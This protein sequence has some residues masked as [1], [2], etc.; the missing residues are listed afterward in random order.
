[1][2]FNKRDVRG[3]IVRRR[4][5]KV[6]CASALLAAVFALA[7]LFGML[8]TDNTRHGLT[9]GAIAA[10]LTP[11]VVF[12]VSFV[13]DVEAV[14][15]HTPHDRYSEYAEYALRLE[16]LY[17]PPL[18]L[19]FFVTTTSLLALRFDL[20]S[21]SLIGVTSATA[22]VLTSAGLLFAPYIFGIVAYFMRL[23]DGWRHPQH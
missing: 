18:W 21:A 17:A 1:M 14:E 15:I 12:I 10:I 8:F 3:T 4:M 11:I 7:T 5:L 20:V 6:M 2:L 13:K 22:V 23:A 9:L 19:A 16:Y